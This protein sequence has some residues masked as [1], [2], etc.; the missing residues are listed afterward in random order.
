MASLLPLSG[1]LGHRNAAHL[2][3]RASFRYTKSQVDQL[4]AL[5]ATEAVEALLVTPAP[6]LD[7]PLYDDPDTPAVE[8]VSWLLPTGL[9]LPDGQPTLRRYVTGW[10]LHEALNDPG[11]THR[12]T[13]FFHQFMAVSILAFGNQHYFDY[14][15]LLKWGALGNFKKLA[16]KMVVDNSMLIYLNNHDNLKYNPNE[17][18]AREFLELFTIGKGP[19]IGPEDYSNYTES[20]IALAAR[21]F[22]GFRARSFRDLYD[23]ETSIPSGRAVINEHDTSDKLFSD[24]FQHTL[25]PGAKTANDMWLEVD[26]F[27]DMV[28]AQEA[29]ANTFCRRLYRWFVSKKITPEIENDI[30]VPLASLFRT[31]GYEI[32]PVLQQLLQSQHFFD[33]DDSDNSDEIVGGI[34][35]SPLD[36]ALQT[37]SFFDIPVSSP[38]HNPLQ[39]YYQEMSLGIGDGMLLDSKFPLFDPPDVAGYP[40]Y[41]QEPIFSRD[42][43]N[44]A[45]IIPRYKFPSKLLS[46]K[47]S[48]GPD[49]EMPI[50]LR[51]DIV[52]WVKNGQVLSNPADPYALVQELLQ[53]LFPEQIDNDRFN[54]FYE[55][56]FLNHLPPADW[57]YEWQHF[58][59]TNDDTEVRIPLEKLIHAIM[60]APE[61]HTY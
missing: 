23:P 16:T 1:P 58:L 8:F 7:Q 55:H 25:I 22:T 4:A 39:L 45:T 12:M 13:L 60:Y 37:I 20:D 2:L 3:R 21:V 51:L 17:N 33:A 57:S 46:G 44:S 6:Q 18:F 9:P 10:W 40:A 5:T 52:F 27:V 49:P 14:L 19:Q 29:T 50:Y 53:Y 24:K 61:F 28:F 26:A 48:Y 41:Y 56:V 54:Y 36:I 30:I 32:K 34:I 15:R 59:D 31:G 47:M 11:V 35:K 42:W 38:V 43:F